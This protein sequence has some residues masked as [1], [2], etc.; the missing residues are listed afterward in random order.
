MI[1][2]DPLTGLDDATKPLRSRLLQVPALRERYIRFVK[3]IATQ[4]RWTAL[5]PVLESRRDLIKPFVERDTRKTHTTESFL[6]DTGS[7]SVQ[8]GLR[9][10]L[11]KRSAFL[12]AWKPS[13]D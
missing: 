6:R 12:L 3:E 5:G 9:N 13:T 2:L 7:S 11:E 10:F 4:M 1:E 8:G